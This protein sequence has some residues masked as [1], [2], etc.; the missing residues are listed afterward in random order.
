[1]QKLQSIRNLIAANRIKT[2][3]THLEQLVKPE[4]E[5]YDAVILFQSRYHRLKQQ[6][7]AGI[8]SQ[9]DATVEQNQ[10]AGGML[11]Y[12]STLQEDDL[13]TEMPAETVVPAYLADLDAL[14]AAGKKR[15]AELLIRKINKIKEALLLEDD[16]SRQF[17]YEVQLEELEAQLL[18]LKGDN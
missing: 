1:M 13:R 11:N 18:R 14:E 8:I 16:P 9:E 3:L 15:Q 10:I 12:L 17:R 7:S 4:V 5:V 2:A 6:Q